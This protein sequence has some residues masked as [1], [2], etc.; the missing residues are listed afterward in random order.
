M[1]STRH[2]ET[3]KAYRLQLVGAWSRNGR[4]QIWHINVL[5][6][7]L[8]VVFSSINL[9]YPKMKHSEKRPA[10]SRYITYKNFVVIRNLTDD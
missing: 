9:T 6:N 3:R 10:G 7:H 8:P 4:P 2:T 5:G 1:C